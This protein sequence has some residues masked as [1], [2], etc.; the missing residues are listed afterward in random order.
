MKII[1]GKSTMS[2]FADLE[3]TLFRNDADT[4]GA[5]IRFCPANSDEEKQLLSQTPNLVFDFEK[6]RSSLLNPLQYGQTL[7]ECLFSDADMRTAFMQAQ[8][9]AQTDDAALRLRLSIRNDAAI[10]H[11]LRWETLRHFDQD[12]PLLTGERIIF[13]RYLS[14]MDWRPVRLLAKGDLSALVVIA[15]PE[16]LSEY[17]LS[18]VDTPEELARAKHGLVN[19]QTTALA[20]KGTATLK[21]ITDQLQIGCDIFYVVCHGTLANGQPLLFLEDDSGQVAST[22][23][24]ELIIRL[25]EL[26]KLPRLAVLVSCQSAGTSQEPSPENEGA[27]A[28]L[29][30]RLAEAGVP[31][32]LA[33]QGNVSM[34]TISRFMPEFF[35]QLQQDGQIDRAISL[36]RGAVREEP[37]W[38][39]P[40]LFTRLKSGR[41]WYTPGFAGDSQSLEIWPALINNIKKNRCTPVL[42]HGLAESLIGQRREIARR[43][44]EHFHFP[45]SPHLQEDLPQVAQFLSVNH[46]IFFPRDQFEAHLRR[47]LIA[48]Y[49]NDL[50][51]NVRDGEIQNLMAAAGQCLREA[52][53]DEPFGSL[54]ELPFPLIIT[55]V[56]NSLLEN[57]LTASGKPP[58]SEICQWNPDIDDIPSVYDE[59]KDYQPS[60]ER[61]LV[62]H[63][64]GRLDKP[65]S[66]V[67]TEDD[68][69]DY[70]IGVTRNNDLIPTTVRRKL[71]DSALL[72]IGFKL[73]DWD[74]RVLFRS[75]MSREGGRRR[76]RYAHVAVQVDPEQGQIIDPGRAKKYLEKYFGDSDISIFWGNAEDFVRE[77]KLQWRKENE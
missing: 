48:R 63:L 52:D 58:E 36:A 8:Q 59:E 13:S 23:G 11:N 9:S 21:N 72:F 43:W 73:D 47:E 30:P 65:E 25:K 71:S 35:T 16:N 62:Y 19:I 49:G 67:L 76:R 70:L 64:F 51:E 40:V 55:T 24:T 41:L 34:K 1:K 18:E 37:D 28:A 7:S 29:G 74:F 15:G 54:S 50:P 33:M 44:A 69:F 60:I 46:D 3:I 2:S 68:Y 57:A 77:L 39:M 38:W 4:F 27:L 56:F 32:V 75:I 66:M 53:P 26:R 10:L 45:L 6:L 17:D 14:S 42:G 20:E 61:P 31:A 22:P 12:A 5:E